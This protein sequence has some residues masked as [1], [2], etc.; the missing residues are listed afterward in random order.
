MQ[1]PVK[2]DKQKNRVIYRELVYLFEELYFENQM[3]EL[4]LYG[5]AFVT[6]EIDTIQVIQIA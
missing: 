4:K 2:P 5:V 1:W 6:N 3:K